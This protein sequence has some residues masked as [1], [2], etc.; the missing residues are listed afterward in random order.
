MIFLFSILIFDFLIITYFFFIFL[1]TFNNKWVNIDTAYVI[2]NKSVLLPFKSEIFTNLYNCGAQN[3]KSTYYF[4]SLET[5]ISNGVYL[6]NIL[7][8]QSK[9]K[10]NIKEYK[11]I[12][13]YIH[14]GVVCVIILITIILYGKKIINLI[15]NNL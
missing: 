10:R 4:T 14:I 1:I 11:Q 13:N 12:T 3:G 15:K 9:I 5:A 6:Y 2:T 7:E 8:P